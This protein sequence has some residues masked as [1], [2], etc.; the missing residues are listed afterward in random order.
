MDRKKVIRNNIILI[1]LVAILVFFVA[2]V[3]D[4]YHGTS[5]MYLT[6]L[7]YLIGAVVWGLVNA[8]IH[9][10]G[11]VIAGKK[12]G[13]FITGVTAWFF[14]W[15]RR[16]KKFQFNFTSIKEQAGYTES[17]PTSVE[18]IEKRV[19]KMSFGGIIASGVFMLLSFIPLFFC[20]KMA[21]WLYSIMA[22]ALPISGYYF[23]G[24]V[25]P[26]ISEGVRNDGAIIDGVNKNADDVKV[27][28]SLLK[29]NAELFN[30]KTYSEIDESYYFD[31]PQL[32][33]DSPYYVGNMI[34]KY[35]FYLDKEDYEN[36]KK[37]TE[38][39]MAITEDLPKDL[40]LACKINALY[41]ACTFNFNDEKADDYMYEVEHLL[42]ADLTPTSLRI[43]LAY[44]LYVAKDL[45]VV[46]DFYKKCF[47]VSK[48]YFVSGIGK[49]ELKLIERMKKDLPREEKIQE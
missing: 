2:F 42:N 40:D 37:I 23:F 19:K 48:K 21:Y 31:L 16:G 20:G 33:E 25:I 13:F 6:I 11:H 44:V 43:R 12:N 45:S 39:L 18:D 34:A 27:M 9:E 36:A 28:I 24:N 4:S 10:L 32:P 5:N 35:N 15:V 38:R 17:I 30:G 46:N 8:L 22:I 1:A 29:I 47:K 14:S 7:F 3:N 26:F 41:D 49:Y